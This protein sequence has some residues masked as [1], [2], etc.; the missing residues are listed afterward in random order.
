[1]NDSTPRLYGM[2][3][4][5]NRQDAAENGMRGEGAADVEGPTY[6]RTI[7]PADQPP[8]EVEQ[9]SGV[10]FAEETRIAPHGGTAPAAAPAPSLE[11]LPT[12]AQIGRAHV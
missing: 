7:S 8:I 12:P 10:A 4:S 11:P 3:D 1:M 5:S 9:V 2:A 6:H